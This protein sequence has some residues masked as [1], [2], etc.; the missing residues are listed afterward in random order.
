MAAVMASGAPVSGGDYVS[1]AD[2][3]KLAGLKTAGIYRAIYR[4][5]LHPVRPLGVRHNVIFRG[6]I[7]AWRARRVWRPTPQE[8]DALIDA[9]YNAEDFIPAT[10]GELA[11]SA[12]PTPTGGAAEA[13]GAFVTPSDLLAAMEHYMREGQALTASVA[14]VVGSATESAMRGWL[15]ATSATG[16]SGS[17]PDVAD[18][19]ARVT[20]SAIR[21]IAE[22]IRA[23]VAPLTEAMAQAA[24]PRPAP[25]A[26]D[27][28]ARQ[29]GALR[30]ELAQLLT[31][32]MDALRPMVERLASGGYVTPEDVAPFM[33]LVGELAGSLA[34][35]PLY[36]LAPRDAPA[37]MPG[38]LAQLA[39][40]ASQTPARTPARDAG[41]E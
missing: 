20:E 40:D 35:S 3:G 2:A 39:T 29:M 34:G 19:A 28:V 21:P 15:A 12:S 33:A 7:L 5:R 27:V 13:S 23:N 14:P 31:R 25:P 8:M 26:E 18:V 11:A 4:G 32:I 16:A 1:V 38:I 30:V 9:G 36:D 24:I 41:K 37:L 22:T 6:E 10:P 17:P